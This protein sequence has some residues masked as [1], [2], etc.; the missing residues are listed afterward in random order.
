MNQPKNRNFL[1]VYPA[2]ITEMPYSI[3]VLAGVLREGGFNIFTVINTFRYPLET[4]D[5]VAIAKKNNIRIVGIS[6]LTFQVLKTFKLIRAFKKE[7]M[8]V[9]VG[10]AHATDCPEEIVSNGADIV[11]RNEGE[12]TLRELSNYWKEEGKVSLNQISGLTFRDKTG[13]IISTPSRERIQNLAEIPLPYYD[14]FDLN[15]FKQPNGLIKG[16]QRIYTS[17]GCPGHCTFCDWK[18]FGQTVSYFPTSLLIDQIKKG[19][20]EYGITS[21]TIADDCFTINRKH[22]YAFCEEIVKIRPSVIWQ[23]ST[24]ANLVDREMLSIMKDAGCYLISFGLES[25]DPESLRKMH[26]GVKL[27]DNI[28]SPKIAHE[29]GLEVYANLMSGFPWETV[30]SIE[31]NIK[32]IREIWNEVFIFQ[33]SGSLIPFPGSKIYEE[34]VD[35]YNFG[36]YWTKPKYQ[37]Y[38]IQTYQNSLNP[39]KVSTFYQR[40]MFD[41]SYIQ[42]DIF[43]NYSKE[44]KLKIKEMVFEIGRHNIEAMFP[45]SPLRQR[46]IKLFS[47]ISNAVY[48]MNPNLEKN[49]VGNIFRPQAGKRSNVEIDRDF[50]RGFV[51]DKEDVF[52]RK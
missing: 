48:M 43:F 11:V 50:K 14:C 49:I 33:V 10:G 45:N 52:T 39:Y 47:K 24:R 3:A 38:G 29:V 8:I 2:L 40:N 16:F 9:V 19:V 30:E 46:F 35:K 12:V 17:R 21:F 7:G 27:K 42:E 20:N 5:F 31:N 28:E 41:D 15:T 13:E 6:M 26:K 44:Y 23:S 32:L 22:V 34:F 36:E 18:V 4:E 51:K 37:D 1:L 25:G